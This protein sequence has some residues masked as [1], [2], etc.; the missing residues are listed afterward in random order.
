MMTR[1]A[2]MLVFVGP[3]LAQTNP[4]EPK[5]PAPLPDPP[6]LAHHLLESP[7]LIEVILLAGAFVCYA[8][9]NAAGKAKLARRGLAVLLVLAVAV[10]ALAAL[11]KT[12]RERAMEAT[13]HLVGDVAD[14][15]TRS[16]DDALAPGAAVYSDQ[17]PQGQPKTVILDKV[18][19]YF[20]PKGQYPIQ[21]HAILESQAFA[22]SESLEQVQIK[23]RVTPKDGF[24]IISWWRMD[25]TPGPSGWQVTGIKLLSSNFP[26]SAGGV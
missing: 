24:P 14:G 10:W 8:A 18:A 22:A 23:V 20:G 1:I 11:V 3:A 7:L 2:A 6:W 5:T 9:L 15:N 21:E 19:Q 12:D 16:V 25:L 4:I 26:L 13:K 17:Y